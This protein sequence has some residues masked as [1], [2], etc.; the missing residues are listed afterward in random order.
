MGHLQRDLSSS[1]LLQDYLGQQG[2]DVL[3]GAFRT[4]RVAY[5]DAWHPVIAALMDDN[6]GLTKPSTSKLSTLGGA[7]SG[8]R[9]QKE[10][11][12]QRFAK[13]FEGLEDLERLH[14][15]YPLSRDD[16]D[17]RESLRR[18][19]L[20]LVMPLYS[21]FVAKQ[22]AAHF[23]SNPTKHLRP[24]AEVEERLMRLYT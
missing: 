17:L 19:V 23:S 21:K 6:V 8:E 9:A 13:F 24:E 2:T 14:M 3:N 5:L 7:S 16:D 10:D 11:A 22:M 20:R 1:S 4:A 18:E 15:A 12:K